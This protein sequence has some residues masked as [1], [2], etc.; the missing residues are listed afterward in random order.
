[1]IAF[2][3]ERPIEVLP[4]VI[5]LLQIL[6]DLGEEVVY[7]GMVKT[8]MSIAILGE[9]GIRHE[10][11]PYEMI[12]FR[13]NPLRRCWQKATQPIRPYLFRSWMWKIIRKLSCEH[14]DL[15]LWSS[16]MR[17][18]AVLGDEALKFGRR[19]IQ[20]LYELG[21]ETGK[22]YLGFN[23]DKLY[24][25][26]TLIEC[27][28]NR[29]HIV[30]A[31]KQ[32]NRLPFILPNKPYYHPRKRDIPVLDARADAVMA[33]WRGKRVFLYQGV[34]QNDRGQLL[35]II[36]SLCKSQQ[37]AVVAVMG[38]RSVLVDQLMRKYDN[39]SYV[40]FV[41]PP[42]H[43][44]VTSRADVGIAYYQGGSVYGLSPL[45]PIYCAPNKIF[46]Y[47]GFGI[48]LICNDV[49]GLKYTIEQ[50][51]AGICL[52]E[53]TDESVSTAAQ[54]ILSNYQK[55]SANAK[56]FFDSVD[57]VAEIKSVLAYARS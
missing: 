9:M 20:S 35:R 2:I 3:Q 49:P 33:S 1:M 34:I 40:P 37:D 12:H 4:P 19:H 15:I 47:T 6:K 28:Y 5:S 25:S 11:Y 54:S 8:E 27:E 14:N 53:I 29:A 51:N 55:Y 21:D 7:L 57:I 45:N 26:A 23:I 16:E 22:D 50:S 32:L 38:R 41:S 52:K 44:E 48:P 24:H 56:K 43:L 18:A 31:E 42:H 36:E 10:L 13:K 39:I 17:T 30:M 46:E